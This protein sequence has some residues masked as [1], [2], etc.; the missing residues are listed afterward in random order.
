MCPYT[1]ILKDFVMMGGVYI[2]TCMGAFLGDGWLPMVDEG[3]AIPA[4]GFGFAKGDA[5]EYAA[6]EGSQAADE[7][8]AYT[9][10][11]NWRGNMERIFYQGGP[12]LEMQQSALDD[13]TTTIIA[14]FTNGKIASATWQFGAG[15]VGHIGPHPEAPP[16]WYITSLMKV[17]HNESL[18]LD[19]VDTAMRTVDMSKAAHW[20][21]HIECANFLS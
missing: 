17:Q 19:V 1:D 5:R 15:A 2:G 10:D 13:P 12:Y 20:T 6:S 4:G 8:K 21:G 9:I 3:Y 11:I 18:V 14:K 7:N 16:S